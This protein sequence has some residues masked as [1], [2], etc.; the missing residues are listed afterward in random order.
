M[1][2]TSLGGIPNWK[3]GLNCSQHQTDWKR[4][5]DAATAPSPVD[6][7]PPSLFCI[8]KH[9]KAHFLLASRV[10][11]GETLLQAARVRPNNQSGFAQGCIEGGGDVGHTL[12]LRGSALGDCGLRSAE[13]LAQFLGAGSRSGEVWVLVGCLGLVIFLC[14]ID[15][16]LIVLWNLSD[17]R[18]HC[19][20]FG[21]RR[22]RRCEYLPV[23]SES[24]RRCC[25]LGR[26]WARASPGEWAGG[27]TALPLA[28]RGEGSSFWR[29]RL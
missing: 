25:W 29:W 11:T 2:D 4:G 15:V 10:P 19:N 20:R 7:R 24:Q 16:C 14:V 22:D 8:R 26:W 3:R 28:C 23:F 5:T 17:P 9:T 6:L 1:G 27:R 21:T 18:F 13:N 12:L